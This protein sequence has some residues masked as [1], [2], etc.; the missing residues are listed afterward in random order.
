VEGGGV[1]VTQWEVLDE[2]CTTVLFLWPC[3]VRGIA[4]VLVEGL[5]G[6]VV[7]IGSGYRVGH[8]EK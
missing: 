7:L 8:R 2:G 4:A 6:F 1:R 5:W 3:V